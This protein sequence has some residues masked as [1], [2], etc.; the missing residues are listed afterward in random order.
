MIALRSRSK[1]ECRSACH[2]LE[3]HALQLGEIGVRQTDDIAE[4]GVH[5]AV[6]VD[7]RERDVEP[8]FADAFI[9]L[10]LGGDPLAVG[11]LIGLVVVGLRLFRP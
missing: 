11:V 4:I 5:A 10:E 2:G 8:L 1:V 9:L 3:V 6:A 7:D